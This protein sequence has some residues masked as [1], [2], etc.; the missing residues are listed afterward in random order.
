VTFRRLANTPGGSSSALVGSNFQ[1]VVVLN[2]LSLSVLGE[3]IVIGDDAGAKSLIFSNSAA[4][5]DLAAN[6]SA[7]RTVQLPDASG[8]LGLITALSAGATLASQSQIVFS[9]FNNVSFGFNGNTITAS[10]NAVGAGPEV[11]AGTQTATPGTVIFSNSNNVVFG[12][13]NSSIVTASVLGQGIA[14]GTQTAS[15]HTVVFSNSNGVSFGMS[16]SSVLTMSVSTQPGTPFGIS[17]NTQSV[18][19][20]TVVFS[21][22][23]GIS[24]GLSGSSQFT[25]SAAFVESISAGSTNAVGNQIVFSNSNGISFGA[26]GATVTAEL[27]AVSYWD[28]LLL[29]TMYT[30][31][32]NGGTSAVSFQRVSLMRMSATRLDAIAHISMGGVAAATYSMLAALYT[33]AGSSA[34]TVSSASQSISWNATTTASAASNL[35]GQSRTRWRSM[36]I[37]TWNITPGEYM[38]GFQMFFTAPSAIIT[39]S[40]VGGGGA[41]TAAQ[42]LFAAG[43]GAYSAYFADGAF[44]SSTSGMPVSIQLSNIIQTGSGVNVLAQPYIRLIGTG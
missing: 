33:F 9:N 39:A 43:G 17:A 2:Q 31:I 28:N 40:F 22:S 41:G 19:T 30:G 36:A 35:G 29:E 32:T 16:N 6:P 13:S 5:L 21:A 26:N 4:E 37:G 10:S 38:L 1:D 34:H 44:N 8:T 3:A 42:T 14:A 11:A 24:F 20:G 27:P 7:N 12:M 25:A 15:T 18:S 23:N